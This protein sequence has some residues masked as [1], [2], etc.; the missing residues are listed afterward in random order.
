MA[1]QA[2]MDKAFEDFEKISQ[3]YRTGKGDLTDEQKEILQRWRSAYGILR[4]YPIQTAAVRKLKAL[5]KISESQAY[6]DVT[7]AM[8]FWNRNAKVN[9]EFLEDWVVNRLLHEVTTSKDESVRAKNLATLQRY[10]EKMPDGSID[11]V[12][13]E[14]NPV[15]I[16]FNINEKHIH[17]SEH[18]VQKLSV[19]HAKKLLESVPHEIIEEADFETLND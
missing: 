8:K 18:N 4:D 11:P 12:H 1:K 5:Y 7:N 19:D 6:C 9:R 15:Y 2:L 3:F 13:S 10:L 17:I 16:S 14:K